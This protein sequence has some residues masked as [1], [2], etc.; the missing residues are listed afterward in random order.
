MSWQWL[1]HVCGVA[2]L[3]SECRAQPLTQEWH[4]PAISEASIA[5][6]FFEPLDRLLSI[7]KRSP[8]AQGLPPVRDWVAEAGSSVLQAAASCY[9]QSNPSEVN[10]LSHLHSDMS[11]SSGSNT[12][13]HRLAFVMM[14]G[15]EWESP[16][17]QPQQ[18]STIAEQ[19]P[20]TQQPDALQQSVQ[21]Q[22]PAT[23]QREPRA[24]H[25]MLGGP[26]LLVNSRNHHF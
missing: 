14:A 23:F 19:Q 25:L 11:A 13:N 24:N 18:H 20:G 9:A 10:R 8:Q 17:E 12:S 22:L 5:H 21:Q 15:K 1:A 26:W 6:A 2:G 16:T 4:T 3:S 7:Q